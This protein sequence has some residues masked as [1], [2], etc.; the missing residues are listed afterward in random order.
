MCL[1]ALKVSYTHILPL[2]DLNH[3]YDMPNSG[4][5]KVDA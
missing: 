5:W 3:V 4:L 2:D 1:N